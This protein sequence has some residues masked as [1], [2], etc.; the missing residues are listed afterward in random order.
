VTD[1]VEVAYPN[2]YEFQAYSLTI[3]WLREQG[4]GKPLK[5]L[6]INDVVL[7]MPSQCSNY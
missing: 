7:F 6:H 1:K 5:M 2:E 3:D 4:V